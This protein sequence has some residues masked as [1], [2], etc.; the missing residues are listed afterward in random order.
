MNTYFQLENGIIDH[1]MEDEDD[2]SELQHL[3]NA[4]SSHQNTGQGSVVVPNEN[5]EMEADM[6]QEQMIT[7]SDL[8][9]L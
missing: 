6:V 1:M 7:R 5:M 4:P 9:P 2:D 3:S 8:W